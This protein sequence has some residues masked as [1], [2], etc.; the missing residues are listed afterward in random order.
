MQNFLAVRG[1]PMKISWEVRPASDFPNGV[2]D[3]AQAVIGERCWVALSSR[4]ILRL[5]HYVTK[6]HSVNTNATARL[7]A[8]VA[9]LD[10]NYDGTSA[11]TAF[12]VEARNEDA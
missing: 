6:W 2:D 5:P 3:L 7:N 8:A 12:G 4:H 9:S 10:A 1:E 11:V